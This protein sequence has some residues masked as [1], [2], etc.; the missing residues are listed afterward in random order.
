MKAMGQNQD[1]RSVLT[2]QRVLAFVQGDRAT[3]KLAGIKKHGGKG[4]HLAIIRV[5]TVLPPLID[6]ASEFLPERIEA[7]LVLDFLAHPDLSHDLAALCT[8]Q[9]IPI[10]ASG[11][12][13]VHPAV[14]APPT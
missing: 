9:F 10:V 7:D 2:P 8:A 4:L 6:D 11:K 13:T 12:K 3:A 1:K 14:L 5:D